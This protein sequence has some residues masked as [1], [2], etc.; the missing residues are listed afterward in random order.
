MCLHLL[1][2]MPKNLFSCCKF[3]SPQMQKKY[4]KKPAARIVCC[5]DYWRWVGFA[6]QL[7]PGMTG[8]QM[9]IFISFLSPFVV[10]SI[11]INQ[12]SFVL[13]N[14][15]YMSCS[16][17]L[18]VSNWCKTIYYALLLYSIGG[19]P[20]WWGHIYCTYHTFFVTSIS[21]FVIFRHQCF[22]RTILNCYVARNLGPKFNATA[23]ASFISF[24]CLCALLKRNYFLLM[25][26]HLCFSSR[27]WLL[28]SF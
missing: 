20:G 23:A 8:S 5:C 22:I 10:N 4:L 24:C 6:K 9:D 3:I 17:E 21:Y 7:H 27:F 16:R 18:V 14:Q 19:F 28:G 11:H 1:S 13:A 15:T 2:I 12:T 25:F 26:L